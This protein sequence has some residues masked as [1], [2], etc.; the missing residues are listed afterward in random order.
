MKCP[1]CNLTNPPEAMLCDCGY[2]FIKNKQEEPKYKYNNPH[3]QQP[4]ITPTAPY[5]KI[6]ISDIQM[7]F[8]SMVGFMVKWAL[9]SIPAFIIISIIIATCLSIFTGL[10]T[11]VGGLLG[12]H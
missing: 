2:N 11:G 12:S 8:G 6:V 7:S 4:P 1:S 10:L 9:A 3:Y 5:E